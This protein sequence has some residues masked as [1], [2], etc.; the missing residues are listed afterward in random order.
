MYSAF[1]VE[2]TIE[3][4]FV[5]GKFVRAV[6]LSAKKAAKV[7]AGGQWSKARGTTKK[8]TA[9]KNL[10]TNEVKPQLAQMKGVSVN[11]GLPKNIGAGGTVRIGSKSQ[12]R[13]YVAGE[14][15]S[16]KAAQSIKLHEAQHANPNRSSYRLHSQIMGSPKK[17]FREEA[18]AD[19]ASQG[20]YSN[21]EGI[22]AYAGAA[23]AQTAMKQGAGKKLFRL[24][25][26]DRKALKQAGIPLKQGPNNKQ[27]LHATL[28]A[29]DAQLPHYRLSEGKRGP[30]AVKAYRGLQ[31]DL[32]Q[33]NVNRPRG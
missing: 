28:Q 12:G 33:R 14:A 24:G 23:R 8:D 15:G 29:I 13:S 1:G 18:R 31:D 4:S 22:S 3:K 19:W 20:H 5:N 6:D 7:R 27:A 17:L 21:P 25:K 16:K 30:K 11:S 9:F 2:H 10:M 26:P 32:Q